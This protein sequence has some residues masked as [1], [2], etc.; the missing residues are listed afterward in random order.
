MTD[1]FNNKTILLNQNRYLPIVLW[2]FPL[3]LLN[4]GWWFFSY[5]DYRWI[6]TDWIEQSNQDAELLSASS[7]FNYCVGKISSSFFADLKSG[8]ESFSGVNQKEQLNKYIGSRANYIFR[9]PFPK[10]NLF[11]FKLLAS[12]N[13]TELIYSNTDK[14]ISKT[15]LL[16]SFE[17]LVRENKLDNT[18]FGEAKNSGAKITNNFLG[19]E[20][21]PSVM[22]ESQ[23]GKVSYSIYQYK[24]HFFIWDYIQHK[25]SG[26]TFG[27]FL[28]IENSK[29]ADAAGRLIALREQRYLQ[30]DK[31]KSFLAAFIPLF[32]GYGGVVASEDF[33]K[34]PE[35]KTFIKEWVPRNIEKLSD[36]EFKPIS[37]ENEKT[38]VGK[39]QAFFHLTN[40]QS[41]AAVLLK[42]MLD[43]FK[44]PFWLY[45][46]NIF[47]IGFIG[48]L[49]FRGFLLGIWPNISLK[50]RFITTYFLA[51][52]MPLGL[53]IIT[54]YGY[55]SEYRHSAIFNDQSRLRSCI[56]QFD[57]RKTLNQEEY[58][59]AFLEIINDPLFLKYLKQF[60]V[61]NQAEP[62]GFPSEAKAVL[63]R[64][65]EILNKDNRYLPIMGITI[66]DER[67]NY[68]SNYGNSECNTF[69]VYEGKEFVDSDKVFD[70]KNF[71][72]EELKIKKS[73]EKSIEVVLYS[74]LISLRNKILEIAPKTKKW[75]KEYNPTWVQKIAMGGYKNARG[76]S[77]ASLT[78]EL[79]NRRNIAISRLAGDKIISSIYDNIIIDE[80][81]R[82]TIYMQWDISDL[83]KKSF[84]SSLHYFA[85]KEPNFVF[86]SYE[87]TPLEVKPWIDLGR[88]SREIEAK[89]KNLADQAYLNNYASHRDD[90]L[91]VIAVPSMKYKDKII[92]GGVSHE[93]LKLAVFKR[94]M[95][96]LFVIVFALITLLVCI[97]FSS[98][99]FIKPIGKLKNVL[100]KVAEGNLDIEIETDSKDE[101]GIMCHEFSDMTR[102]LSERNKLATLLSDHAVEALS[103]KEEGSGAISDVETFKGTALVTDIRNFTGMCEK[104][105]PEQI[106]D[107]LNKHFAF[108]TKIFSANGGRIYKYIGD[109]IE[110]V[111]SDND[112][113]EKNSTER[114]FI[115]AIE[116]LNTLREIN[117]ERKKKNLFEY[118]IGIGLCYSTMSSGSIGSIDT[119]LDYAILGDAL[120]NAAKLESFSKLNPELPLI[121]DGQFISI[122]NKNFKNISF[123]LIK[124]ENGLEGFKIQN[125][126]LDNLLKLINVCKFTDSDEIEFWG[127]KNNTSEIGESQ[128]ESFEIKESIPFWEKFVSGFI[129]IIFF[130]VVL[131]TGFHFVDKTEIES[132]KLEFITN[133]QRTLEQ[134][135]CDDYGK[136]AFDNKCRTIAKSL[137]DKINLLKTDE[138]LSD[139]MIIRALDD[140]YKSDNSIIGLGLNKV[141][142]RIGDVTDCKKLITN[143]EAFFDT[144]PIY[145]I[146]I[147]GYTKEETKKISDTVKI[148]FI[149][150]KYSDFAYEAISDYEGFIDILPIYPQFNRSYIKQFIEKSKATIVSSL[151]KE[152]LRFL[153]D[154]Y[155]EPCREVFGD[156][157]TVFLL[158]YDLQ[159]GIR[160]ATIKNEDCFLFNLDYYTNKNKI[161]YLF[162]SMSVKNAYNS[163]PLILSSYFKKEEN[164]IAINQ[165][166]GECFFS[167]NIPLFIKE[168]VNQICFDNHKIKTEKRE[169][170]IKDYLSSLNDIIYDDE[171]KDNN[172]GEIKINNDI[173]DIFIFELNYKEKY[174]KVFKYFLILFVGILLLYVFVNTIKG[175][176]IITHSIPAKLWLT[177]L[178]VAVIPILT[179]F[180]VFSLYLNEYLS[181]EKSQKRGEMQRLMTNFEGKKE[182]SYPLVWHD[183]KRNYSSDAL[184]SY[185]R[186]LNNKSNSNDSRK[187]ALKDLRK[188]FQIM[189]ENNNKRAKEEQVSKDIISCHISNVS[190]SGKAGWSFCSSDNE[191]EDSIEDKKMD[192]ESFEKREQ[193]NTGKFQSSSNT[194]TYL[195]DYVGGQDDTFGIMLKMVVKFLMNRQ[196][197]GNAAP[198]SL[199]DTAADEIAI[200]TSLEIVKAFF[201][202]DTFIKI[203]HG[204]N[205]PIILNIGFGKFGL[206]ISSYPNFK[207]PEA[208]FVWLVIIET[209]DYLKDIQDKIET[210]IK[211]FINESFRYGTVAEKTKDNN[212]RIPLGKYMSWLSSSFLPI[213]TSIKLNDDNYLVEC[214]PAL[215]Q[216][217]SIFV[218]LASEKDINDK[219]N[220]KVYIFCV[221][222]IISLTII[223]ITTKNIADDIIN[224]VKALIIG[225]KE[226]NRENFSFRINSDRTDELGA[227]CLSFDRMI[228]G[229]DEKRMM[230]HMLSKTARMVTLDERTVTS[231]KTDAVLL[232]IGIPEFSKVMESLG[233]YE[234]F[235]LLKKH[236]SV[237]AG[238]IMEEGGEVDKIIGEKMLAVFRVNNN[239]SE[240]AL[241]AYRVVKR[242]LDLER[243]N[244]LSFSIAIGLNYGNVINGFLGV[245]NKRDFTVIGDPVNVSAR[246]E[247]LAECLE[248]N[249]CVIS[250]TFY[251]L[252]NNTVNATVYGEVELKGKSQPMKVYQLS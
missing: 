178:I 146:A 113:F 155:G 244:Q 134:I 44:M 124:K 70:P 107:L 12:N 141:F 79:V 59:T 187:K 54:S 33:S 154:N 148:L 106:T 131:F 3:L 115:A 96:C 71:P 193:E 53:L 234:V 164:V 26:D 206:M 16:K 103:K 221:L 186:I 169:F 199:K 135:R 194:V 17:Y 100:D 182:F 144:L 110:V 195:D 209:I 133:S 222:L 181:V 119:R 243:T 151:K 63:R 246:I 173:Y 10:H 22:A 42:P 252:V 39:Y 228:K 93:Y 249:R 229:L 128:V 21:D 92:V 162:L 38:K 13:K 25:K 211:I 176:S 125:L 223:I 230:S 237:M 140:S 34:I 200:G 36:W 49:L 138:M 174:K 235:G 84:M 191:N 117:L 172:N 122:F 240:V 185:I 216:I 198:K 208:V 73:N 188:Y 101:F 120:K 77:E 104:Y 81:P 123:S 75:T 68:F 64:A 136:I 47:I 86:T 196:S 102:E 150:E 11:V 159:N 205:I 67:G 197:G 91:T 179:V 1:D 190:I 226:V 83:D 126:T 31:D 130:I 142:V 163:V 2:L 40:G 203:S 180:F 46:L 94:L 121:V 167:D 202:E 95:I 132:K 183:I 160:E 137:Q 76:G 9:Y 108:M 78:E 189:I 114:A 251:K 220:N 239:K 85:L 48:L 145:P 66:L 6:E 57:T 111:F 165:K 28:L 143:F 41:H 7:D 170:P 50:L 14:I 177:L 4:I 247:S 129:F 69:K 98:K 35:Y 152:F 227:L 248:N 218:M 52:C 147:S 87:K 55:V 97:Y 118:K 157:V 215:T 82:F 80:I 242:M 30:K 29:E 217:N 245:G 18:F 112:D 219:V 74:F 24:P 158:N 61:V 201:G 105:N 89:S 88:H 139:D 171:S 51:A 65:L 166:N 27:F 15:A 153:R 175:T 231:A 56:N 109:A 45:L 62:Q 224:P 37:I 241:A 214:A 210:D 32:A 213:S 225:I 43:K 192:F 149:K 19:G 212:L 99:I 236:T 233:N 207:N 161:G 156:K 60:D 238:I 23:R 20:T 204:I 250:E 232:Y 168:K 5:I 72:P 184:D 8:I 116:M 90:N 58:K 127:N